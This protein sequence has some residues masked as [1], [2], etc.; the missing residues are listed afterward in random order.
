M[1]RGF[2]GENYSQI[3]LLV[4]NLRCQDQEGP[5]LYYKNRFPNEILKINRIKG[6]LNFVFSAHFKHIKYGYN[7]G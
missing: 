2:L 1:N 6:K 3:L 7:H 4:K 5:G